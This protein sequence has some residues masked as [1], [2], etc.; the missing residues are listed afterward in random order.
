M[1]S[2]LKHITYFPTLGP[3]EQHWFCLID[4]NVELASTSLTPVSSKSS[5]PL[6]SEVQ[7]RFHGAPVTSTGPMPVSPRAPLLPSVYT[8]DCP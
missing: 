4:S 3:F 6:C 7:Q 8:L 2:F 1:E 5:V